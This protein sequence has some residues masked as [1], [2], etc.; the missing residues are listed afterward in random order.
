[1]KHVVNV[2]NR[3]IYRSGDHHQQE[4]H[5][6]EKLLEGDLHC[7]EN[8][9]EPAHTLRGMPLIKAKRYLED[10]LAHKQ[11]ILFTRLCHGNGD[12][13]AEVKGWMWML[14]TSFTSRQTRHENKD[15]VYLVL[16]KELSV[17]IKR[18][19][20]HVVNVNNRSIY[21]CDNH[22]QQEEHHNEKIL[23]GDLHCFEN[24]RETAHALHGMPLIKAKRYLE[25]V[26]A[27]KQAILFTRLCRGV[28][29][30]SWTSKELPFKWTRTL[31]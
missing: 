17:I 1:I 30:T 4:E 3:S 31:A 14:F 18:D 8:T 2:N 19:I 7:S 13:D 11:A 26:L 29:R 10:A 25:D 24:T 6:N 15:V 20:K 22:H 23:E 16:T 5:H 12:I 28:G 21:Q 9:K 27:H